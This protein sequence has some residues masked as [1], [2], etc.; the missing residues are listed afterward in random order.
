MSSEIETLN[1]KYWM[2]RDYTWLLAVATVIL[3]MLLGGAMFQLRASREKV[4]TLKAEKATL[5][6]NDTNYVIRMQGKDLHIEDIRPYDVVGPLDILG[7]Y[8]VLKS[9]GEVVATV[10]T[11]TRPLRGLR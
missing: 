7:P 4:A 5:D 1:R 3:G 9:D 2:L 10:E 8:Y 11:P 6:F